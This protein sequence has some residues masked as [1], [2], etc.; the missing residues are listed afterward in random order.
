MPVK[1]SAALLSATL[2][3]FAAHA[4][5]QLW[6]SPYGLSPAE[7]L[8][9]HQPASGLLSGGIQLGTAL[10]GNTTLGVRFLPMLMQALL[11]LAAFLLTRAA[12][13]R[14]SPAWSA[15]VLA[16]VFPGVA[17]LSLL[18]YHPG[19]WAWSGLLWI[20]IAIALACASPRLKILRVAVLG[21][22][23]IAT[24]SLLNTSLPRAVLA[25]VGYNLPLSTDPTTPLRGWPELGRLTA[26][27][28][29]KLETG[30]RM[31]TTTPVYA[32]L[33]AFH[34]PGQ[35]SVATPGQG[36]LTDLPSG[37]L[38]LFV[39]PAGA[40]VPAAVRSQF[41]QCE[42]LAKAAV[43][44]ND[45]TPLRQARYDVCWNLPTLAMR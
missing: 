35:P 12:S 36:A 31:A 34:T 16:A 22:S 14:T 21:L 25:Q 29:A 28:L 30:T 6:L 17:G 11:P 24:L 10:F 43:M 15:F 38:L 45:T 44:L 32:A 39:S 13:G 20:P 8:L 27:Q 41:N 19:L 1:T 4:V 5:Y 2:L 23:L 26:L 33:L 42:F 37:S 40:G 3:L 18:A 7:A 9:W